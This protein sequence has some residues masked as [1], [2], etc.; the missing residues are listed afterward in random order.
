M[1]GY[2]LLKINGIDKI[3]ENM[4]KHFFLTRGSI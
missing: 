1:R 4:K 3:D 2:F